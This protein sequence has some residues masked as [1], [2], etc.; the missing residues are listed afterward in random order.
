MSF[1]SQLII[2]ILHY[3]AVS[4]LLASALLSLFIKKRRWKLIFMFLTLLFIGV[5][6]FVY[7]SGVLF[8]IV[9]IIIIFFFLSL[10]IFSSQVK[11]FG[12]SEKP[13]R[14]GR[15]N[16]NPAAVVF[17][18]LL[19]F[20]FCGVIGYLIYVYSYSFIRGMVVVEDVTIASLGDITGL[21]LN[22][23]GIVAILMIAL[24]VVSFFWF[25]IIGR[26]EK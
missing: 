14:E 6:S 9:G 4:G 1:E 5:L 21:F 19:P 2:I 24:L 17:N 13:K 22:E 11:L 8:F 20:L 16:N 25:L 7:Y 18:I 10:N 3:I 26:D 23:Y 15:L 12:R